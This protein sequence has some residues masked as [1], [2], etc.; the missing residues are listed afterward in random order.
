[1]PEFQHLNLVQVVERKPFIPIGGGPKKGPL[2]KYNLEHRQEHY[3]KLTSQLKAIKEL[4]DQELKIRVDNGLPELP[5]ANVLPVFL[6]ID[7][8]AKDIEALKSFGIEIISEEEEGFIIGA[9]SDG[10]KAFS[11][12]LEQFLT[13]SNKKFKDS[14]ASIL[15]I[16]TEP[17]ERLKR[18]VSAGILSKWEYLDQEVE[19]VVYIAISSYLKIPDYPTKLPEQSD[20]SYSTAVERWKARYQEWQIVKDELAMQRQTAFE[21]FIRPYNGVFVGAV[22]QYSEFDDG[23][24]CKI[25]VS[26]TGLKDLALRF[27]FVFNIEEHDPLYSFQGTSELERFLDVE[28]IAPNN[29]NAKICIID[30]GIQEG[31]RL[32][33]PA[34]DGAL[35][36]SYVPG[37]PDTFDK[38]PGGGHGTRVAGAT[39]FP[40]GIDSAMAS[41]QAP[42]WIQNARILDD[43]SNLSSRLDEAD[44]MRII[45]ERFKP[46]KIFNLSVSNGRPEMHVHMPIWSA[47]ID[48][49]IWENDVLFFIA[50]GNIPTH[51]NNADIP[52]VLDYIN[53]GI[54]YPEF[55]KDAKSRIT[56]PAFSCFSITVGSISD[57]EFENETYK[58]LAEKNYPSSFSRSGLG[59]W[60][61][62]KPD[63]VEYGGDFVIDKTTKNNVIMHEEASPNLIRSTR[64][65][66]PAVGSDVV[67]TSFTTPKVTHIAAALQNLYPTESCLLYRAL[68]IQ[69]AKIPLLATNIPDFIFHYG[70]GVPDLADATTNSKRRVTL[71]NS[72]SV[73]PKNSNIYLIKIPAELRRPGFDFKILIEI[74]LS[75]KAEPRIT[76]RKTK[77]YVSAW[78]DWET[79][80][81]GESL[82]LFSDRILESKVEE[83]ESLDDASDENM[84]EVNT[85]QT[86]A[87][88]FKWTIAS[89]GKDGELIGIKR[90]DNTVQ[91]DWCSEKSNQL[92]EEFLVAVKGHKGWE[93][94]LDKEIPYSIV[95]SFELL[96]AE[97]D[98]DIDIYNLIRVE[99][100]IEVESQQQIKA[101]F[102]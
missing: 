62:I 89:K 5:N 77:S 38:V 39:L 44:L 68:I 23:F 31:H 28:V 99:N 79:S 71:Y 57:S 45:V 35:S 37:D 36:I 63:V 58:C 11:D 69:S 49:I 41:I 87:E 12:R 10:F 2:T 32:L 18:I 53:Q 84:T 6:Q 88:P 73:N 20:E 92:P 95:V 13:Q 27:P 48:K 70:Y 102:D 97:I 1:M 66:G 90:Q 46:T 55:L 76:R 83:D 85:N 59:L 98:I 101:V 75:Y 50:A 24:G 33:A 80:R 7:L 8:T 47:S 22:S 19:I 56:N 65:N 82:K 74:T 91:K 43:E 21:D 17:T 51:S 93:K 61:M 3:D 60:G 4:W 54:N 30:S 72:G 42:F 15:E 78:L 26:G 96:D 25:R 40:S 29:N 16:I 81:K 67:G 34:I 52:G 94:D 100:Q 86:K 64:D 14:A 9:N